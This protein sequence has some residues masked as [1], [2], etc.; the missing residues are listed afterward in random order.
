MTR[1]GRA[2]GAMGTGRPAVGVDIAAAWLARL[3]RELMEL[4]AGAATEGK[5]PGGGCL[6][7]GIRPPQ[8]GSAKFRPFWAACAAAWTVSATP[9]SAGSAGR[10]DRPAPPGPPG[11][12]VAVARACGG[13]CATGA[14]PKAQ[15]GGSRAAGAAATDN[16]LDSE[17]VKA[18]S[19][20][21]EWRRLAWRRLRRRPLR[22]ARWAPPARARARPAR[23]DC[24]LSC[25]VR[26]VMGPGPRPWPSWTP[27]FARAH[28]AG[29]WASAGAG[30]GSGAAA[31]GGGPATLRAVAAPWGG[32]RVTA[33]CEVEPV[34]GSVAAAGPGSLR[35]YG[36]R[37]GVRRRCALRRGIVQAAH[38]Y[39]HSSVFDGAGMWVGWACLVTA[40]MC[41]LGLSPRSWLRDAPRPRRC[42][43]CA[44]ATSGAAWMCACERGR[45]VP[46]RSESLGLECRRWGSD[47]ACPSGSWPPRGGAGTLERGARGVRAPGGRRPGGRPVGTHLAA[48]WGDVSGCATW[49]GLTAGLGGLHPAVHELHSLAGPLPPGAPRQPRARSALVAGASR[50][51]RLRLSVLP[52]SAPQA[53]GLWGPLQRQMRSHIWSAYALGGMGWRGEAI[54]RSGARKQCALASSRTLPRSVPAHQL[55]F[56]PAIFVLHPCPAWCVR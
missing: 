42:W 19:M 22:T 4:K 27:R 35:G 24:G 29:G 11:P 30:V 54:C 10:R 39:T 38:P 5:P 56:T 46:A 26:L 32:G 48:R 7:G 8:T 45:W 43:R 47:A 44:A 40:S 31:G 2:A 33:Q 52:R 51:R 1:W 36:G 50:P 13:G 12:Y 23:W 18:R 25:G 49:G 3:E 21:A 41:T 34:L 17:L 15:V 20:L 55:A 28:A 9:R 16:D 53:G 6:V 37:L 14:T